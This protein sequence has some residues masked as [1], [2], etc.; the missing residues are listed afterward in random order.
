MCYR[1]TLFAQ[2]QVI[3]FYLGHRLQESSIAIQRRK[4]SM[5]QNS[6]S[7]DFPGTSQTGGTT[8]NP[9]TSSA[10]TGTAAAT[11]LA[12]TAQEY[13]GKITEVASHARDFVTDK[14]GVV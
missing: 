12:Q 5:S 9:G 13:G 14:V 6:T 8:G 7:T 1:G 4:H 11:G 3:N 2:T 10:G